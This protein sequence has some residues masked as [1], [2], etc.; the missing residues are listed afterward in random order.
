M[1][2]PLPQQSNRRSD[3]QEAPRASR[4]LAWASERAHRFDRLLRRRPGGSLVLARTSRPLHLNARWRFDLH[5]AR[6]QQ[7]AAALRPIIRLTIAPTLGARALGDRSGAITLAG[8][9]SANA[10]ALVSGS[11]LQGTLPVA[12]WP[13]RESRDAESSPSRVSLPIAGLD[14]THIR[15]L[16][17]VLARAEASYTNDRAGQPERRS[18]DGGDSQSLA[19][20]RPL[21]LAPVAERRASDHQRIERHVVRGNF[22]VHQSPELTADAIATAARNGVA[23]AQAEAAQHMRVEPVPAEPPHVDVDRLTDQVV[24]Q[25]DRRLESYRERMGRTF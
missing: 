10:S 9:T 2:T 17:R 15:P 4:W 24:R 18:T 16:A 23:Q 6:W 14:M 21:A 8:A 3:P 22:T 13:T 5:F 19:T 11:P 1:I 20:L 25:L 12:A 7:A